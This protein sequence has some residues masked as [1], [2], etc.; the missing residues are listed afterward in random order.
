MPVKSQRPSVHVIDDCVHCGMAMEFT[1]TASITQVQC[2]ACSCVTEVDIGKATTI[3]VTNYSA[4]FTPPP[5][6]HSSS[7]PPHENSKPQAHSVSVKDSQLYDALNIPTDA[8]S[9]QI[10]KAYRKMAI[11]FHPD[12]NPDPN[13]VDQVCTLTQMR[14]YLVVDLCIY[15]PRVDVTNYFSLKKYQMRTMFCQILSNVTNMIVLG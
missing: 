12:K 9:D 8:T 4:T 6:S 11:R 13:A 1:P 14:E 7:P 5:P 2:F 3:P 10:K 15:S